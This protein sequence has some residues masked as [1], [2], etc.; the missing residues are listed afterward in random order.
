MVGP[1]EHVNKLE[2]AFNCYVFIK[3]MFKFFIS[4]II[5]LSVRIF[6]LK[7]KGCKIYVGLRSLVDT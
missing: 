7:I 4:D 5:N 3:P 1:A 2:R 6:I